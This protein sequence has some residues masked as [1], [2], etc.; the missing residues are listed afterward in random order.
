MP[1][2]R[3]I[4][5]TAF[6]LCF[7]LYGASASAETH[8]STYLS[9]SDLSPLLLPPPA[10]EGSA[11][12]KHDIQSVIQQQKLVTPEQ[13]SAISDEQH[14]RIELMTKIMGTN[15]TSEKFP[16]TFALLTHVYT[17]TLLITEADKKFWH[18]RRPYLTDPK[19]KLLIDPI[20][21]SPAYPSGHTSSS[22]VVAEV[23]GMVVPEKLSAL[24]DRAEMIA[25]DRIAAGVHYPSDIEAGRMLAL[26]IV[27]ALLQNHDFQND[28][29]AAR[30]EM[31][32][33]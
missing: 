4:N 5:L 11:E 31:G 1:A 29:A 9:P 8:S 6:V 26:L 20:D 32:T 22:R 3:F 10:S 12:W 14:I 7:F 17:D 21:A 23:L 15:F 16:K 2:L 28:L 27:G 24:R 13:L 33:P 18:T 25:E 19:V 30:E